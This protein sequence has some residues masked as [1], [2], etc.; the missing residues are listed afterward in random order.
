MGEHGC[1]P[2]FQIQPQYDSV[3]F[4]QENQKIETG[5]GVGAWNIVRNLGLYSVLELRQTTK[6]CVW[7]G[8]YRL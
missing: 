4:Q 8:G 2:V 3:C 6:D 5:C 7:E 1:Q